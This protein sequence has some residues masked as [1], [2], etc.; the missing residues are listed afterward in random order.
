LI[1]EFDRSAAATLEKTAAVGQ[2][3]T[4]TA[5]GLTQTAESTSRQAG[6]VASASEQ[7]SVE[8]A[9]GGRRRQKSST[10]RS[11]RSAAGAERLD[12]GRRA[13]QQAEKT[14]QQSRAWPRRR[15][16]SATW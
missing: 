12:H 4:S 7:A 13:V 9:D 15:R 6:A 16:R 10:P 11:P 8:R 3:A 14:N 2:A 5:E 1:V